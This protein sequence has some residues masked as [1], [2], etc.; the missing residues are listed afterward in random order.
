[1]VDCHYFLRSEDLE[2]V[3]VE[4]VAL[5]L[6]VSFITKLVVVELK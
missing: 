2:V 5:T 4:L 1:M 3:A 6:Y